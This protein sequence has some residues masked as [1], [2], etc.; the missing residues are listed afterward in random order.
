MSIMDR[1]RSIFAQRV[2]K[3]S[4][5]DLQSSPGWSHRADAGVH[6][7]EDSAL[8]VSTSWACGTLIARSIAGLPAQVMA[9]RG[10]EIA[11]GD[12]VLVDHPVEGLLQREPNADMAAFPFKEAMVLQAIFH[13]NGYAEIER[14]Q[15]GRPHALWPIHP[16]RIRPMRD[17]NAAAALYYEVNNGTGGTTDL[18]AAD[19]FHLRGPSLDGLVGMSLISYA[20]HTFGLAIAQEQFA[21]SFIRN[22]AAPAGILTVKQAISAD[23]LA[24]VRAEVEQLYGGPRRAG[25]TAIIDQGTEWKS[26]SVSPADAEFLAQRRFSVEEICRWF[27]VPPQKIGDT[28]KQ[29]F[30]N[31]E[32]ANLNFLSDAVSPWISR[33]EQECDRKLFRTIPGRARPFVRLDASAIVRTNLEAQYRSFALGRQWGWLSVN[34]IR[35]KINMD[36]IGAEGDVYLTPMN[37]EPVSD[38]PPDDQPVEP[39]EP[40]PARRRSTALVRVK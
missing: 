30:A 31:F 15:T 39:S 26:V 18:P 38:P 10:A 16:D 24:R 13:G 28:S 35:R 17:M 37:M 6:V 11:D 21:G 27:G 25:R 7:N 12:Q 4:S 3:P 34:D 20:R 2:T 1:L 22:R 19:M 32:Q 36:P 33:F 23:G 40:A 5:D 9:R 8:N 29:T 14:D